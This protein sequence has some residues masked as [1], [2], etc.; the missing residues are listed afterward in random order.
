M[1]IPKSTVIVNDP[2]ITNASDVPKSTIIVHDPWLNTLLQ[3][4]LTQLTD[5]QNSLQDGLNDMADFKN[6]LAL[7]QSGYNLLNQEVSS[8]S[9]SYSSLS[10]NVTNISTAVDDLTD[11]FGVLTSTVDDL[12]SSV[13]QLQSNTL[14]FGELYP[15]FL[16]DPVVI[17]ATTGGRYLTIS[18]DSSFLNRTFTG[19]NDLSDY[20]CPASYDLG[21]P[22]K[23]A[24]PVTSVTTNTVIHTTFSKV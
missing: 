24:Q 17:S 22:F 21:E 11:H 2:I 8:L 16:A 7:L 5:L 6:Q 1:S 4:Y 13:V 18:D 14:K 15:C 3:T 12:S 9:A 20:E 19:G 23:L 10:S